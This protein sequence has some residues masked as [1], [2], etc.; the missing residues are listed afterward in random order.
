MSRTSISDLGSLPGRQIRP[1]DEF[2]PRLHGFDKPTI[3]AV[4]TPL[5]EM[6][7]LP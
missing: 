7:H 1:G 4:V 3:T 6:S 5:V 2:S